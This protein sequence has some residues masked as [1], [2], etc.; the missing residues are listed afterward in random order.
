VPFEFSAKKLVYGGDSLGY[1][2]GSPVLVPLTL[3]GER[4]EVEPVRRAKGMVHARPVR[5]LSP[6]PDRALPPCPYFGCCG[7][8]QYQHLDPSR[9]ISAKREILR[10]TL[11]RLGKIVWEADILTRAAS[12]WNY[13]NQA[14]LKLSRT[15][16]GRTLVGFFEAESHRLVDIDECLILSPRLNAVLRKLR[17]QGS[18]EG[19]PGTQSAWAECREIELLADDQDEH[20]MMT[21]RGR[22]GAKEG[23]RLAEHLLDRFSPCLET[24]AISRGGTP[25]V[26][27]K[28]ALLYAVGDFRYQISPG[29]FFQASRFLLPE[30]VAAVTGTEDASPTATPETHIADSLALDLFAGVGLFTLPLA[31]HYAQVIAVEGNPTS[32]ADLAASVNQYRLGNVRA[33]AQSAFDFLRRF[34]QA[35][36]DL[37][38]L[39]PPRSGVGI[40]TLKLLTALR[41]KRIHYASCHPPT[42]ARDLHFLIERGYG[43]DSVEFFDFFPHTYHIECLTKLTW[44]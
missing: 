28:P 23:E 14:E 36:P 3:P 29:S 15:S 44:A 20:L 39:D 33:M 37:V 4:L 32:A 30:F 22:I 12:P 38:I 31:R 1:H 11:R 18:F 17:E 16:D 21:L 9:Q 2:E 25:Q 42:L 34:A 8:C 6:S 43:I 41:P 40:P 27:G 35:E 19:A 24:A 7:G 10:E 13:R 5:V 26:F